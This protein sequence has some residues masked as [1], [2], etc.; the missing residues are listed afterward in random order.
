MSTISIYSKP[1]PLFFEYILIF[2]I[3][4]NKLL[5]ILFSFFINQYLIL[6]EGYP[7]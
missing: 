2:L 5:Y 1:I 3:K 6:T 4:N 7:F